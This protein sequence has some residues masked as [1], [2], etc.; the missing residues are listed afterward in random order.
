[1]ILVATTRFIKTPILVDKEEEEVNYR[2]YGSFRSYKP[3]NFR[4]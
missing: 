2:G 3:T 4:G 1:M